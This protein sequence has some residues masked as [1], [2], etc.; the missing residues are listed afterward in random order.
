MLLEYTEV[1]Q[2][3]TPREAGFAARMVNVMVFFSI[4]RVTEGCVAKGVPELSGP[5]PHTPI[6]STQFVR[7]RHELD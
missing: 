5:D 1:V 7:V 3:T 2:L 6:G 4:V